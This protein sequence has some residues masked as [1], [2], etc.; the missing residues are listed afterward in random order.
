MK[1]KALPTTLS[2]SMLAA[3]V[4]STSVQAAPEPAPVFVK[5][6]S[7]TLVDRLVK[8]R[9][10]YQ[11]NPAVLNTI[12]KEN[13]EPYVDFEGFARGVMGQYYRQATPAQRT[14]F[15]Q[16]FRQSLIRTYAKGLAA[17]NNESYSIRPFTPGRDPSKAVVSMDFKTSNGTIPVTYQLI[18]SGESWK[19]RNVSLN[20]IDIGLTF[21]NQFSST[22]QSNKGN[23]DNA[24]KNFTPSADA[25]GNR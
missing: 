11:K 14:T 20:G 1:F 7:D 9:A 25:A 2:A 18:Q 21:R 12:V 13:I 10:N 23:L 22:V 4:A 16:T 5:R 15:T 3:M 19:V 8:E 6:I 24:I 17:Y